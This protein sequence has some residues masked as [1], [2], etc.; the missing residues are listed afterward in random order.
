[1]TRYGR[2]IAN[3]RPNN[4]EIYLDGIPVLDSEDQIART[5]K[6]I[7]NVSEGI[8]NVTF[9]KLG[10]DTTTVMVN[11]QE[12]LDCYARAILATKSIRY[13]FMLGQQHVESIQPSPGWPALPIPQIPYG[14]LV[15]NTIPDGAEIYIDGRP[16]FDS[17]GK[18]STTPASVLGIVVGGH[19]VT[20]RKKG[21]SDMNVRI[22]IENGLYS[23][24]YAEL[25]PIISSP[26]ISSPSML[27]SVSVQA[28]GEITID[29]TPGGA[30]IYIDSKLMYD[31]NGNP[32]RTPAKLTLNEGWHD[33]VV[34]LEK[35]CR[36]A[37]PIYVYPNSITSVNKKLFTPPCV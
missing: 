24:A 28:K 5:P 27:Q 15:A 9:S 3:T 18:I 34:Y 32:I 7:L 35:F 29:T 36:E 20:F 2:I 23:D 30:E 14:N 11:V 6:I 22:Y 31:N 19:D 16:V 1:M 17:V 8:H 25:K 26:S 12:D 4:I 10:Y 21:F 37:T 13:P 33:M